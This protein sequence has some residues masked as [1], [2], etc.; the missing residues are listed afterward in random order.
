MQSTG[1]VRSAAADS[2]D[3]MDS[4]LYTLAIHVLAGHSFDSYCQTDLFLL[5]QKTNSGGICK[6]VRPPEVC[7]FVE[8]AGRV[9]EPAA[10]EA[11]PPADQV[12]LVVVEA[13]PWCQVVAGAVAWA[14][15]Q[16]STILDV[17]KSSAHQMS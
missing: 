8:Q 16:D 3:S 11:R 9:A 4:R 5:W 1:I 2:M 6:C 10:A 14:V 7:A 17:Y 15:D 13:R 12:S